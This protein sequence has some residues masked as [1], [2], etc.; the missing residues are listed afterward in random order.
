MA[1]TG[2]IFEDVQNAA[3][4]LLGRGLNPT[5]QRVRELLGTGSNTTISEHLKTWQQQ[6]AEAPKIVLPPTV[7][8]AVMVALDG[9]WKIAVQSAEA[10]FK[11]QRA[12][13][14]QAVTVAEQS[15]DHAI[16]EQRLAET[17][18]EQRQREVG[19]LSAKASELAAQ[20]LIEQERRNVAEATI[21]AAEQRAQ[22]TLTTAAE[23]RTEALARVQQ[24]EMALQQA[25]HD[26]SQ[27]NIESQR[28]LAAEYQRAEATEIRLTQLLEQ[29]RSES[30]AERQLIINERNDWK[31][32]EKTWEARFDAQERDYAAAR[33]ALAVTTERQRSLVAEA[34]QLRTQLEQAESRH[35]QALR[36]A[37]NLRGELKVV[38]EARPSLE[39]AD[40]KKRPT[41]Q[42]QKAVPASK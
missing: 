3:E 40:T 10:V 21:S 20:L 30:A 17:N 29:Q 42:R 15:R 35:L 38:L 39:P 25:R 18:A 14:M 36:T 16:A 23:L 5:I 41:R 6:L 33:E 24:L 11:E 19:I 32:Q 13:A 22:A 31:N 1:R 8:E 26:L 37:E 9:F 27:Q 28:L 7:P 4:A 2:I 34:Q 12:A